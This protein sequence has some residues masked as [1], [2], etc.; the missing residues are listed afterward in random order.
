MGEEGAGK[1]GGRDETTQSGISYGVFTANLAISLTQGPVMKMKMIYFQMISWNVA[2]T[3]TVETM[4][5]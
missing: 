4:S 5:K 2:L 1:G 3:L